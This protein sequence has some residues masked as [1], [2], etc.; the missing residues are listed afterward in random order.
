MESSWRFFIITELLLLIWA[1]YLLLGNVP[2]LLFMI[3][4]II[5]FVYS[6]KKF[7]KHHL[8]TFKSSLVCL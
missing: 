7:I 1:A 4:A 3:F 5:N 2:I 6:M 8:I